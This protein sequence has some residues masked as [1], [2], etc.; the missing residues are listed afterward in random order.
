M[1]EYE[2]GVVDYRESSLYKFHKNFCPDNIFDVAG[3]K[4]TSVESLLPLGSYPWGKW[5]NR[6]GSV[7]WS[8]SRHCGPSEDS[9]IEK[10][11]NDFISLFNKIK[12]EGLNYKK[13]GNPLG[14]FFINSTQERFF[15]VLGGNHRAAIAY[16]LKEKVMPVRLLPRNY[17]SNQVVKYKDVN[18]C[19]LSVKVFE[20]IVSND[21][22]NWETKDHE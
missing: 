4:K 11:W 12:E 8:K 2:G 1:H 10:E 16:F 20:Y 19:N 7:E 5:T 13:Y 9:L 14:I 3:I 18:Q 6:K 17:I 15:I 22:I 21:F